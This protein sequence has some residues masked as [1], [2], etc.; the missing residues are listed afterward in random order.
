[1]NIPARVN[2]CEVGPRDGLQ[3]E[4]KILSAE[5]KAELI[6]D[7]IEA[8]YR[9]IEIGSFVHPKAVPALADTEEVFAKV[10]KDN[11]VDFRALI[12]N[13]IGVERAIDAGVPKVKL[14]VSASKSHNLSNFNKNPEE[15]LKDF[16]ECYKYAKE[17][18]LEVSAAIS[19]SFGCPF[20][21]DISIGQIE[22]IILRIREIGITEI[23]LSDTTGMANPVEVYQKFRYVKEQYPEIK[24][25]AH[26][27]N[28][29]DMAMANTLAAIQ[30]GVFN[31]DAS[32]SG[33]G[34]CPYAPGA[35]GNVSSEDLVHSLEEMN[36]DTGIDLDKSIELAHKVKNLIG[37]ETDSY[38]IK[39]G[40]VDDLINEHPAEQ[41]KIDD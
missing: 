32:F 29:R 11:N 39:A 22:K 20:E 15:T 31:F 35:S 30:A 41:K 23:S 4:D 8:G 40:K 3:N 36:I 13:L 26:F 5:T 7:A 17:N 9:T 24:W 27:H 19:T 38:M 10:N 1:M 28:T 2:I 18:S 37:H 6:N 33:L 14:T 16:E 34:G 25:N 12:T 21:G